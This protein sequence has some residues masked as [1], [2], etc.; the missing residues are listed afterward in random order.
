[1]PG[2]KMTLSLDMPA[3]A[4]QPLHAR[5]VAGWSEMLDI[6]DLRVALK[7]YLLMHYK[8][9]EPLSYGAPNRLFPMFIIDM[10]CTLTEKP[11]LLRFTR[12]GSNAGNMIDS[13]LIQIGD[14]SMTNLCFTSLGEFNWE[15]REATH[16]MCF[17]T[18][19]ALVLRSA[20]AIPGTNHN[21]TIA[22]AIAT[23]L[24]LNV[25]VYMD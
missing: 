22:G 6:D 14:M 7:E 13:A 20:G 19:N 18:Y 15:H 11:I 8:E 5:T 12:T 16:L 23:A 1:M 3:F 17:A 9:D 25:P 24:K 10:L 4:R 2:K 21:I